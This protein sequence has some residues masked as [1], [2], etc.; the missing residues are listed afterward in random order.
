[1]VFFI[2]YFL[3]IQAEKLRATVIGFSSKSVTARTAFH[4]FL[5]PPPISSWASSLRK[6]KR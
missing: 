5:F 2:N 4:L 1:M 6:R 3:G